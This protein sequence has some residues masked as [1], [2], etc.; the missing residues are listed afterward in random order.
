MGNACNP[1]MFCS[2]YRSWLTTMA[3]EGGPTTMDA[4]AVSLIVGHREAC[5]RCR[6][7]EEFSRQT[8]DVV[9]ALC[10]AQGFRTAAT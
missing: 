8:D 6:H 7:D 5:P 1:T 4:V 2:I 10:C 9:A 3:A